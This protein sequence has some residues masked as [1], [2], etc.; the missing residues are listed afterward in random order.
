MNEDIIRHKNLQLD[1]LHMVWCSGAC[2]G[3]LHRFTDELIT[4]EMVEMVERNTKRL[5]TWWNGAIFRIDKYPT[6]SEWHQQYAER[7]ARKVVRSD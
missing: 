2:P 3:G 1:A 4:Q 6:A 5:R 7:L